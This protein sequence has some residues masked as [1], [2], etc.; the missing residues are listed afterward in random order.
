MEYKTCESRKGN[1]RIAK[2]VCEARLASGKCRV[3]KA[4][5]EEAIKQ[6]ISDEERQRRSDRMKN[7]RKEIKENGTSQDNSV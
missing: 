1:P 2:T 3:T 6:N 5:C 4:G 7:L